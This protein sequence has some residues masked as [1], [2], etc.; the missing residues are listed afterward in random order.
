[1]T[2][3]KKKTVIMPNIGQDAMKLNHSYIASDNVQ[4]YKHC[5]FLKEKKKN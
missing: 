4:W 2:E 1:M 3:K 5:Q